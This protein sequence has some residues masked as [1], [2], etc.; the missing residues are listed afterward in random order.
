[1]HILIQ[2]NFF[3]FLFN[4]LLN[5][6]NAISIKLTHLDTKLNIPFYVSTNNGIFLCT[7]HSALHRVL[8]IQISNIKLSSDNYLYA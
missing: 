5:Y 4:M 7:R 2:I 1:M 3:F 8:G 6:N